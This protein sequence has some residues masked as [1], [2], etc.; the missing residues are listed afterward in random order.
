M[1]Q[2]TVAAG[3]ARGLID[4]A[5]GKGAD[6]RALAE[7]SGI[8]P[9]EIEDQDNRI[10][11]ARY[12]ALMRAAKD[13]TGDPALALHYGEAVDITDLSIVGLLSQACATPMEAFAEVRRYTPL[14]VD[15]DMGDADRMELV[16]EG[17]TFWLV[18]RRPDP[19]AFPELTE[20]AFARMMSG[21]R[22]LGLAAPLREVHVTHEAPSYRAEY[23]RIFQ[24]PVVFSSHW[25]AV[26]FDPA[27]MSARIALQPRYMFGVLSE[28]AD[29]LLGELERENTMRGSIER[30][31]IPMLHTGQASLAAVAARLGLSRQTLHRRLKAEG[32]TFE[33]VRDALRHRLALD[34]LGDRKVSV[35]E[36]AYRLGFADRAAFSRA[37][38]RWQGCG[39]GAMRG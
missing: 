27:I 12:V 28:R 14:A 22:R 6:R 9:G 8:A 32:A 34:Y 29:A 25:N 39:P 11:F 1:F 35:N 2:P 36:A 30:L 31:L 33:Q 26:R 5:A 4:F 18:D 21:A 7:R 15:L 17:D 37:F 10:P 38:K 20:S 16:A 24:A 3:F 19:N 13:L 23:D